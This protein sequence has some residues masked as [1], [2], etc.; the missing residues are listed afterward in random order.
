MLSSLKKLFGIRE[1][2]R[3]MD[4][5][6]AQLQALRDQ[7]TAASDELHHVREELRNVEAELRAVLLNETQMI[8]GL[9]EL[10]SRRVPLDRDGN[11]KRKPIVIP[12]RD[13]T[14]DVGI[15]LVEFLSSY[16]PSRHAILSG[17]GAS[18]MPRGLMEAGYTVHVSDSTPENAQQPSSLGEGEETPS[19]IGLLAAGSPDAT[20]EAL[21]R[22]G[23]KSAVA[24]VQ[25]EP[26]QAARLEPFASEMRRQGYE[27]HIVLYRTDDGASASYYCNQIGCIAGLRSNVVFFQHRAL[28]A[29]ALQWC[30]AVLPPTYF[31]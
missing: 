31:Q 1:L 20:L 16:L 13:Q 26:S 19:E 24:L 6:F 2:V 28:F 8:D 29:R 27:W 15:R 7:S 17:T 3:I 21:R 9:T 12:A 10:L 22:I 5:N 14:V 11:D 4:F 18:G 25:C 30:E 23:N